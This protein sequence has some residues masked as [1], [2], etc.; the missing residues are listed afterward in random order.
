M[1]E[2]PSYSITSTFPSQTQSSISLSLSSV[3]HD[4]G[5][6]SSTIGEHLKW[7]KPKNPPISTRPS[8]PIPNPN[9]PS[10]IQSTRCKSTISSL[11]ISTFTNN[12]N[13]ETSQHKT[14]KKTKV[15]DFIFEGFW[16][17]SPAGGRCAS[18]YQVIGLVG[19]GGRK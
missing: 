19:G 15:Q 10:I 16:V 11:L 14:Q 2:I 17:H 13:P 1:I 9:I 5:F 3:Y 18:D 7:R 4:N 12:T 6:R 8:D